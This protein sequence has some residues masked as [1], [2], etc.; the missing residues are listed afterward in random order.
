MTDS[1]A[2]GANS[3]NE[4]VMTGGGY[5]D[6]HSQTQGSAADHGLAQL[7]RAVDLLS[8]DTPVVTVADLGCAQGHNSLRPIAAAIA[9]LRARTDAPVDVVHTDL[10]TNDWATLFQV[11][12]SDPASYLVQA[13]AV[14]AFVAGRSFYER[15]FPADGLSIA[16]TS[17]ALHWLSR[18][19][20]PIADHFFVQSSS[21]ETARTKY[22][23]QAA[24]DWQAFL[25]HRSTELAVTGAV[26]FVDV[27]MGADRAMGSETLFDC[28]EA[29]LRA[30]ATTVASPPPSTPP[31]PTR[32][33]SARS[34]SSGRRSRRRSPARV[35]VS[36]NWPS[37]SRPSSPT[38]SS[39]RS[40]AP[41]T[42]PHTDRRRPASS[43]ASSDPRSAPRSSRARTSMRR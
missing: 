25:G 22:R 43:P 4:G 41:A 7:T 6:R 13:S 5:Y 14:H 38:R 37:S 12:D 19:P 32:R 8:L 20:G 30:R 29:A 1:T 16:W 24:A 33:G 42:P 39:T 10:P 27:L 40:R 35:A 18:S 17:S 2:D 36:S 34:T 21:D 3:D 9:A 26:V 31:S 23:D 15:I 11:I 28:L